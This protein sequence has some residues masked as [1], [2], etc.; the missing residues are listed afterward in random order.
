MR[1]GLPALGNCPEVPQWRE[2]L[3][4]I[5]TGAEAFKS[6]DFST[7]KV[8]LAD[9]AATATRDERQAFSCSLGISALYRALA[10]AYCSHLHEDKRI[11]RRLNQIGLRFLHLAMNW[12]THTFVTTNHDQALIDGSAWPIGIQDINN[13]LT[14]VVAA[15]QNSGPM[16]HAPT[17]AGKNIPHDFRQPDLRIAIVSLCTDLTTPWI[18]ASSCFV[19]AM[20]PPQSM[21]DLEALSAAEIRR[22]L[23]REGVSCR[24]CIEKTDF[25]RLAAK[26]FGLDGSQPEAKPP[27]P[28]EDGERSPSSGS[29]RSDWSEEALKAKA[30]DAKAQKEAKKSPRRRRDDS[31]DLSPSQMRPIDWTVDSMKISADDAAALT[32]GAGGRTVERIQRV[33]EAEVELLDKELI[34]EVRGTDKQRRRAKKYANIIMKQRMGPNMITEDF[35]DGDLTILLV[36]PDVVGYVQGQ[37][38][39]VLRSI[40]EEWG[41]L[42]VFIDSDLSKAQ[43]LAVFGSIRGRRGSELKVLSAIETKMGGYFASV[44]DSVIS[45]DKFKDP[46]KTWGTDTMTFRDEGEISYALGKQ[47]GTRK[48]LE[49]S[50]G[51]IVQYV[52]MVAVVSGTKSERCRVREY[53]KWLFQQLEG[54]VYVA[55]WEE[56]EDCTVV[57]I[58]SDC[59]GYIT[60]NRRA[61]L[62]LMEE[63]WGTLMF[64]MSE[65]GGRGRGGGTER[66]AI[67][68]PQRPRRGSELKVMSGIETKSP[69]FFTRGIREK[70]SERRGFDTDRM[71][72]RD[73]ELSYAL[74]KDG[75]TRKKLELASGAILQYVGHVA[76][77]GGTLKERRRCRE[78]VNWLLQQRRGSVTITD[79][80]RREDVTEVKIPDSCKGWV[81]G[82]RGSE[83]R[84]M[85]QETGTFMFMALDARGDERLLIFSTYAGTKTGL[86]G[87]RH[88]ERLV[89]EMIDEKLRSDMDRRGGR[90]SRSDS[91]R[92]RRRSSRSPSWSPRARS[93]SPRGMHHPLPRFS[94]SNQGT[95]AAKH[96]YTSGAETVADAMAWSTWRIL[97][98]LTGELTCELEAKDPTISQLKKS[99]E[100][101]INI[102]PARQNLLQCERLMKDSE[103]VS[104]HP[105]AGELQLLIRPKAGDLQPDRWV[106]IR[107][108]DKHYIGQHICVLVTHVEDDLVKVEYCCYW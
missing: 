58:P 25:V 61:T 107:G 1:F 20:S 32:F 57:D 9:A 90:R 89:N 86:G 22:L 103:V 48:K 100:K 2:L 79:L 49:R 65:E 34:L 63:E 10:Y 74:G 31:R 91:R 73:D 97:N 78:F 17:M 29:V 4:T 28:A 15:I 87:R 106:E 64:F 50:S 19:L 35:E 27:E 99:I 13:D 96:G 21:Q 101:E 80:H 56:R 8:L 55:G 92:Q 77:I 93:R 39:M 11:M 53:M 88:A 41:T 105:S 98:G 76:F 47:G 45:R 5:N 46:T 23:T 85:E 3:Q 94:S 60:G 36:P 26:T 42:M 30:N 70:Q 108:W 7:A 95:Y 59:I 52:G 54:P 72:F 40:E 68:G 104:W 14:S 62:G 71:I 18:D 12:L 33:S 44:R 102:H 81:T 16:G 83:L 24:G 66:L 69:G 6:G 75:A 82:N 67:F 38:G 37:G 84:R 51:A 43:R